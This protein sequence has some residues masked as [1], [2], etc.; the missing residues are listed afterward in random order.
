MT[1]L[2]NDYFMF[3]LQQVTS[4]QCLDLQN[5]GGLHRLQAAHVLSASPLSLIIIA[6]LL[7]S[8]QAHFRLAGIDTKLGQQSL[9]GNS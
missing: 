2:G 4:A 3:S 1:F 7:S 6:W 8:F 5:H 9:Q